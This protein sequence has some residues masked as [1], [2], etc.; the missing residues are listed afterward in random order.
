MPATNL[1]H[2]SVCATD[3]EAS[4]QFYVELFG[5]EELPTPN[6]GFPVRW[7]RVGEHQ[8]HLFERAVGAP[9]YHHVALTVDRLE[10]VYAAAKELDCLDRA[11]FG[12]FLYELPGDCAQLYIRDPAGNL[13]EVDAHGA[14]RLPESVRRDMKRLADVRPQDEENLRAT[15]F[16]TPSVV[17][18]PASRNR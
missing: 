3:L 14:S 13:I 12:H 7:L 10:P 11:T 6:F 9:I 16:H 15:L 4:T 8:L 2:A 18:A 5:M 1:N 17:V